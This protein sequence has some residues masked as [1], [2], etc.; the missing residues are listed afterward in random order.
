MSYRIAARWF[1][2]VHDAALGDAIGRAS[3]ASREDAERLAIEGASLR[4]G[5]NQAR[6]AF[7]GVVD[8]LGKK[9]A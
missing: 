2:R 9:R 8:S 7:R 4:L 3:G 6:S 5:L 1:A